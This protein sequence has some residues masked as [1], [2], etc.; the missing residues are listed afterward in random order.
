[1]AIKTMELWTELSISRPSCS[2]YARQQTIVIACQSSLQGSG[3]NLELYC[4]PYRPIRSQA[5]STNPFHLVMRKKMG[6]FFCQI[7]EWVWGRAKFLGKLPKNREGKWGF[8]FSRASIHSWGV[9][10][11]NGS[12]LAGFVIWVSWEIEEHSCVFANHGTIGEEDGV[13]DFKDGLEGN[14]SN[15]RVIYDLSCCI[16]KQIFG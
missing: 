10:K 9:R 14:L 13:I 15:T 12:E 8:S 2:H 1:M 11:I 7:S 5:T 4:S 16:C 6:G 3:S